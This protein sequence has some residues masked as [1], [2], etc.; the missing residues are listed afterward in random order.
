MVPLDR[1]H[2]LMHMRLETL[3]WLIASWEDEEGVGA[4]E[5]LYK[6]LEFR[7]SMDFL[8]KES[9]DLQQRLLESE[10][11]TLGCPCCE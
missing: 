4:P 7:K 3:E 11:H 2:D 1:V 5:L 8:E 6:V 10:G 9:F